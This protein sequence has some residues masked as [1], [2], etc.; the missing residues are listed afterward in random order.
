LLDAST[1][2]MT[3]AVLKTFVDVLEANERRLG[4]I[5]ELTTTLDA[6]MKA[7]RLTGKKASLTLKIEVA[8]DKNDELALTMSAD[9]K[10][11]IPVEE[12]KKAL[13]YHDEATKTFSKTDPRQLELLAEQEAEKQEREERLRQQGV[14][15][16]NQIG[17]G[18]EVAATA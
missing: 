16:L 9:V 13:I 4:T 17:R 1:P 2:T 5:A 15:S 6:I 12:R 10:A 18:T 8:P 11:S 14:A 7:S 3:E